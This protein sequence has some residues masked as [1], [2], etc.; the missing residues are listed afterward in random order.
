[1]A[2]LSQNVRNKVPNDALPE[3]HTIFKARVNV[4]EHTK[5]ICSN[6]CFLLCTIYSKMQQN[7]LKCIITIQYESKCIMKV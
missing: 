3:A 1:M 4:V 5:Q 7:I 6:E 2:M